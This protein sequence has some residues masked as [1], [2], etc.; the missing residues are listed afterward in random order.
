MAGGGRRAADGLPSS[1]VSRSWILLSLLFVV[2]AGCADGGQSDVFKEG[3][4]IYGDVCSVCHGDRGQ[5]LVGPALDAVLETWPSCDEHVEWVRLGSEGWLETRGDTY[6]A[7]GKP[8]DGGMPAHADK[9]TLEEIR[10]VAAF[11]R[12]A[13]GGQAEQA[14]LDDCGV[15]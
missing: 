3:R 4:S 8:V 5:G 12:V 1:A 10:L 13:Y 7:T 2:L 6:G 15:G 14:A 9:L 11:Q